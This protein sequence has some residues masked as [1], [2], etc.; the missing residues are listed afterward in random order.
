MRIII[1]DVLTLT[2]NRERDVGRYSI[3]LDRGRIR[4]VTRGTIKRR[5][6]DRIID[7][8]RLIAVPGLIN[9]HIHCDITL[10]RGLGDGL[11]LYEQDFDSRVSRSRW[12]REE[13]DGEARHLSRLLQYAE[14]VKGGTTFICDVPFWWYGDDLA[15][16]FREVGVSGAV[17]LDFRKD[18]L[19]GEQVEREEYFRAAGSL[20]DRDILPIA[21]AP[22][23]EGFEDDLLLQLRAW[24][25]DLDTFIHLHLAE[26]TWRK[27]IMRERFNRSSVVYLHEI[28]FLDDRVIGSH[29][30]YLDERDRQL[31]RESGARIVNCPAA[32]MK[33][34]DGIAPVVEL[35]SLGVPLGL[36]TDGALWNDASDMFAEMKSLMLLQRVAKGAGTVSGS[37]CLY[38]ATLGG[39]MVFGLEQE[40][41][42]IEVGK[43]GSIVL[44]NLDKPHLVPLHSGDNS[45][46]YELVTSCVRASDVDTVL[47]DGRVVVENGT[48]LT[49]DEQSLIRRCQALAEKR[50]SGDVS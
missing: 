4:K 13:L 39:A 12:F 48:L 21:E 36:G 26:T 14:A 7:G 25:R 49:M 11:T 45:N 43:R 24:A 18:F 27:D 31:L 2:M 10:A 47:V 34:A 17:V 35:M 1:E 15:A 44:I 23:E 28:G 19:T 38:A 9:G 46:V 37:D 42:S 40:L 16:P 50:F 30:V 41:G 8:N 3:L 20:R 6:E 29:G 33:I 32:E 5:P 22:A